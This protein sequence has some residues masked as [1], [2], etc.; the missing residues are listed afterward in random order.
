MDP[1]ERRENFKEKKEM[2]SV[3]TPRVSGSNPNPPPHEPH[4]ETVPPPEG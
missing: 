2:G 4:D 1:G 3:L